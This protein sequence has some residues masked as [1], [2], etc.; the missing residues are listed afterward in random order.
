MGF[1]LMLAQCSRSWFFVFLLSFLAF[2]ASG[3]RAAVRGVVTDEVTG[4]ALPFVSVVVQG[5]TSGA[6]TDFDGAFEL[7][8]LPPGIVNL[9][10][11]SVGYKTA[12]R[13]EIELT[14]ARPAFISVALEP[15]TVAVEAAEVVAETGRG[16]EEAPVSLRRIG[17]NEIKR[18]PGGGRDISKAIRSLP[19][20]AA[21]PSF[22]NDVV[23][24]GG[25]PNE[26]RFYIDG[27]EIPNI[28]H[29]ATQGAS[30]GPVG[31]INVDLVEQV[32]FYSG[33]FPSTRGNAL[34]SVMEFGFKTA[35][36]DEWTSNAVV[37]TSD[38]GLT[39][40]GPTGPKSS[41]IFSAR[42]SYLQFLFELIGLPFLPIYNDFQFKWVHHPSPNERLTV[43]G[44]GAY[45]DFQLNL[46]VADDTSAEDYID[47]VAIL[48]AL[49]VNQQWNYTV[50]VKY[51]KFTEDGRWSWI[52][53]RNMLSNRAF[54]HVSNDVDLPL[55]L[56]YLS[57]EMENKLRLERRRYGAEGFKLTWGAQYEFAKFN[58]RTYSQRYLFLQDTLVEIDFE[59]AFDLHK[60]G[61]FIQAS[62]PMADGR[63]TLSGGLRMD[64]NEVNANMANPIRQLS[65][66]VAFRWNFAPRWSLNANTGRYFQLPSYLVLGYAEGGQLANQAAA[67]YTRCDQAVAGLRFDWGERNTTFGLEG[68]LKS[69]QGSPV[70]R[71]TG[72]ALANLGADF[73]VVGN[74]AVLFDGIGRSYG[75][76]FL[77]QRRLYKGVY[78]LLAYTLVRSEYEFEGE[79]APSAWDSRHIVSLT[80]GAK[81]KR[82]WEVGVRWLYSGG[83][84]YTPYDIDV[85][86]DREYWDSQ[87]VPQLDYALLN[88]NRNASFSQL[89]L[90]V[91]KKWFFKNWSLDVFM[92]IQNLFSQVPDAPPSLDVLRDP[93]TGLPIP[94]PQSPGRYQPRYINANAGTVV[95]AIG[96]IVEL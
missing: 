77:A 45:D 38:L 5:A 47:Q 33:A 87:G 56:D 62:K 28:N 20:V 82:D 8:D 36:T 64:G 6:S 40:E 25:A 53:S 32:E 29:F 58:N 93:A 41:L 16:E 60:Y 49:Q 74:E 95:P 59:S 52:A 65:P 83:L 79:F 71:E 78:G 12:T 3:Q 69:Y 89:D 81:L 1:K 27:I 91:D 17:T 50:G 43:L 2:G 30:G 39:F 80:G 13:L 86:M 73:G 23:I 4:L 42:R 15:L 46:S 76:E 84:P 68:F 18:N 55:T 34:S 51:D 88:A 19:G 94:D 72:I 96:L 70:S 85:S 22:R 24:R 54:K 66:R 63:I 37:G 21:I 90:R 75:L 67:R 92:D 26:N 9:S 11:S 61:A 48:D 14:P 7:G 10:F 35:R 44:I 31:M 57:Q